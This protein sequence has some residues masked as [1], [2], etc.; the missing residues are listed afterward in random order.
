M[1]KSNSRRESADDESSS[2]LLFLQEFFVTLVKR[3][4]LLSSAIFKSSILN[5]TEFLDLSLHCNKFALKLFQ[6]ICVVPIYKDRNAC[7]FILTCIWACQIFDSHLILDP[8][9]ILNPNQMLDPR[10]N[11][12][13]PHK[14]C[15]P[16]KFSTGVTHLPIHSWDPGAQ[17]THEPKQP[18]SPHNPHNLAD[19]K[20]SI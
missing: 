19:S 20:R 7:I 16:C 11:F 2:L 3:F 14:Q 1:H 6:S 8:S 12:I 18:T 13:D 17:V 5:M 10:E 15:D 9:Q 4:Q